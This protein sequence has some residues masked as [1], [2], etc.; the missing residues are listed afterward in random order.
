MNRMCRAASALI[1]LFPMSG[2]SAQS[3]FES[4]DS[5]IVEDG[6]RV[7]IR[8]DNDSVVVRRGTVWTTRLYS[9]FVLRPHHS[10][11]CWAPARRSVS[12]SRLRTK[13]AAH[14]GQYSSAIDSGRSTS[15]P[16]PG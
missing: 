14:D 12:C 3:G 8:R 6:P 11:T 10:S 13:P 15:A 7:E 16:I 4:I 9:D 5:R 1:V 2:A